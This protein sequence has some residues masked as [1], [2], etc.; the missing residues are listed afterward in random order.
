MRSCAAAI[1]VFLAPWL[2]AQGLSVGS[3]EARPE[4]EWLARTNIYEIWLNGFSEEGTLRGAI[5]R[6]D[7]VADLGAGVLYLGPIAKRSGIPHASPY[8][9]ADYNTIDPQYGNEQD[10]HDFVA[11]AHQL[12]MKVMLDIV[13]YHTAPD[14]VLMQH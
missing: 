11:R 5:P 1:A 9:I 3:G 7:A 13:Y 6:L 4:P 14:G 10:L 8:N 12:G 2:A